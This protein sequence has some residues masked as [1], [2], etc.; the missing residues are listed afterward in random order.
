MG[1]RQIVKE[2][3]KNGIRTRKTV[4]VTKKRVGK[5]RK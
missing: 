2:S 3:T 1:K 4:T 5:K